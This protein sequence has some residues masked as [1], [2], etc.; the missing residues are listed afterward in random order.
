MAITY[1]DI[2]DDLRAVY[3]DIEKYQGMQTI[4]STVWELHTGAIYRWE[5]SGYIELV[6]ES[7]ARLTEAASYATLAAGKWFY[8]A[9]VDIL[10]VWATGSVNPNTLVYQYGVDWDAFK[11]L[12]RN[13]AQEILENLL[14]DVMVTPFQKVVTPDIS[15]NSALYDTTIVRATALLTCYNIIGS[16][17]PGDP[18]AI[19]L[20]KMVDNPAPEPGE[21][22]GLVQRIKDGQ[23]ALKTQ[24]VAREAGAFN[25]WESVNNGATAFWEITGHYGGHLYQLWRVQIDTAGV[26]G[27]ATYKL[28]FDGG[29]TFDQTLQ[30]TYESEGDVKKV[31][32]GSGIY[33]RF[34]GTFTLGD[35]IDIEVI[36]ETE[37]ADI[38][39]FGN[40]KAYR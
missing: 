11:T 23:I 17:R 9:D 37:V 27:T 19:R 22:L 33:I 31:H 28:S 25:W 15:Y 38:Q 7:G 5:N 26:P 2:D 3:R 14:R 34:V 1:C 39:S 21:M 8:D 40:I 35:Y 16:L 13:D 24:R 32:I 20:Y 4:D 10:Y 36:P 18:E 30:D 6:I 12:Q 29:A